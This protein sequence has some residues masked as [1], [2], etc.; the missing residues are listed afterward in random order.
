MAT[1]RQGFRHKQEVVS[2]LL[3]AGFEAIAPESPSEELKGMVNRKKV[4]L[5]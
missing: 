5:L 1:H 2:L 4:A 3:R